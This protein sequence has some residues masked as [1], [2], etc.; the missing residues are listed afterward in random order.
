M[1]Q[2]QF[3]VLRGK[4]NLLVPQFPWLSGDTDN[5]YLRMLQQGLNEL[6][7]VNIWSSLWHLVSV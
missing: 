1:F 6:L 3:K 7:F 2:A 5:S 4:L